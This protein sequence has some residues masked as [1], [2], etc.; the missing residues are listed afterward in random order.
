MSKDDTMTIEYN[1]MMNWPVCARTR[2][3]ARLVHVVYGGM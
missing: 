1:V 3:A 2:C